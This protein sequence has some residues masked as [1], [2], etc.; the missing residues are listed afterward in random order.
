MRYCKP[1][2]NC[3][4]DLLIWVSRFYLS[5]KVTGIPTS[6]QLRA[7][8][9]GYG[10]EPLLGPLARFWD[11]IV[12]TCEDPIVLHQADCPCLSVQEEALILALRYLQRAD[13]VAYASALAP[14]MPSS[15]A[16]FLRPDLQELSAAL[17]ALSDEIQRRRARSALRPR[18]GRPKLRLVR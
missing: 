11:A 17:S 14:V 18:D 4:V 7:E 3:A 13:V 9:V 12:A 5:N 16:R 15:T 2:L 10:A 8:I 1:N 6:R